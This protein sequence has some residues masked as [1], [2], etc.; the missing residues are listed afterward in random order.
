[1]AAIGPSQSEFSQ[2]KKISAP[3]KTHTTGWVL[4]PTSGKTIPL[5]LSLGLIF[6]RLLL[7]A[8]ALGWNL[9]RLL[10]ASSTP[11]PGLDLTEESSLGLV[12]QTYYD[13]ARACSG[14]KLPMPVNEPGFSGDEDF[15][16]RHLD[17]AVLNFLHQTRAEVGLPP[18]DTIRGP[19]LEGGSLFP[20]SKLASKTHVQWCVLNPRKSIIGYFQPRDIHAT[21]V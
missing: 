2:E 18:F 20:G 4:A 6:S 19:F 14:A 10:A 8:S 3:A 15:I 12:Q 1:M 13:F 21:A 16:K 5:A 9:H 11:A 17:C 7:A